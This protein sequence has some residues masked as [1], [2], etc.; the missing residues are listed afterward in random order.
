MATKNIDALILYSCN[1][2]HEHSS[3]E[4]IGVFTDMKKLSG[5]INDMKSAGKLAKEDAE[6]LLEHHQTQG[7]QENYMIE[8]E[9][10]NPLYNDK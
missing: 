10:L 8:E 1:A 7:L 5:Y 6:E 2:W 9:A 4:L 3:K